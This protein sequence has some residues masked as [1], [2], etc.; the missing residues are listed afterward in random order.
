[1]FGTAN[2]RPPPDQL[3]KTQAN[4]VNSWCRYDPAVCAAQ[5]GTEAAFI[6]VAYAAM[7][8]VTGGAVPGPATLLK[9]LAVFITVSMAA[10]LISDDLG[11]KLSITAVSG[12]GA[13]CVA[14]L[15]PKFVGW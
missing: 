11:N 13:K 9:F 15:A 4:Q 14:I 1:M 6:A 2:H 8:F 10:R 7:L 5:V 12:I 3:A